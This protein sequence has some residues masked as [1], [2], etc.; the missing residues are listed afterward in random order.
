[1]TELEGKIGK[2]LGRPQTAALATISGSGAPWV[3]YVTIRTEPDFTLNFCTSLSSRKAGEIA[4]HPEVHLTC[5]NLQPPD[6]SAYLQVAG[7]AEIRSDA[8]TKGKYWQDEWQRYF[9]GP[10]DPEYIIVFIH[11][12]RIEYNAPGSFEPEIWGK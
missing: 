9:K 1:M 8:A 6:D 12:T 3:R 5:G 2:I 11:P 10:E 7:R 4:A